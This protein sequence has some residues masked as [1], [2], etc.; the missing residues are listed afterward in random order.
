MVLRRLPVGRRSVLWNVEAAFFSQKR[1]ALEKEEEEVVF[2]CL[3]CVEG[4]GSSRGWNVAQ[5]VCL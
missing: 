1:D 2:V 4:V 5:C 3:C